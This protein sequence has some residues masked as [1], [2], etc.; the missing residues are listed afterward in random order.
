MC[1]I[2]IQVYIDE[3]GLT[4]DEQ[5]ILIEMVGKRYNTGNR[6]IK[7]KTERFP[8]RIENKKYLT[9]QLEAL[10]EESRRLAAT[11]LNI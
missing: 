7:L 11:D 9:Y 8:N 10:L 4:E 5:H 6:E 3:L 1:H 2:C